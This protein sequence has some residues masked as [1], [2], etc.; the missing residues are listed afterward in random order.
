MRVVHL[1]DYGGPY[2][3]SFIPM[4]RAIFAAVR[5]RGWLPEAVFTESARRREWLA[6]LAADDVP[7]HFLPTRPTRRARSELSALLA[8]RATPQIVHTHFTGFDIPAVLAAARPTPKVFWHIHMGASDALGVRV[9]NRIKYSLL[10]RRVEAILCVSP[11][12]AEAARD[13]GAPANRVV[14]VPNAIDTARFPVATADERRAARAQLGLPE[15]GVVLLHFGWDWHRKG[16]DLFLEA[17]RRLRADANGSV[18]GLVAGGEEEAHALAREL[19]LGDGVAIRAPAERVQ[20]L[21]AAAD[22][23]V[24]SS[25]AEGMPFAV[26]EALASGLPVVATRIPGHVALCDGVPSCRLTGFD[27]GEI[28][29]AVRSLRDRDDARAAAERTAARARVVAEMDLRPWS[30][31]IAGM[32]ERALARDGSR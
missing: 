2:A 29:Q 5:R 15:H 32:Y 22:V 8:G 16:G 24:S 23:F 6:E 31:R 18:V 11:D 20:T 12:G 3:G 30:E 26:L 4:L 17:V 7:V 9:R 21:Y 19:E 1:A 28:A 10:A 25:R 14:F 13:R 27:P